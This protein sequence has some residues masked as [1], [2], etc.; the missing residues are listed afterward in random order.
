MTIV[1]K[2]NEFPTHIAKTNNKVAANK[3]I[4]I[5]NQSIYNG[6]LNKF[7]RAIAVENMHDYISLEVKKSGYAGTNIDKQCDIRYKFYTVLN[8]GS[9]SMRK[10]VI[11][12]KPSSSN[13]IPNWDIENLASI[14]I[15]TGNDT[16]VKEGVIVDDNVSI[17]RSVTY[18][19]IEVEDLTDRKIE[20][21]ISLKK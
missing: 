18:E 13:Y 14:W 8:H 19:F 3:F 4:K 11:H 7:G 17:I 2:L 1:I 5:N 10:G 15:K 21:E 16:L 6:A 9:I 12:W 20:I